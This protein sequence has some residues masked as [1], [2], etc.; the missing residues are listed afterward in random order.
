MAFQLSIHPWVHMAQ[1]DGN[2]WTEKF[3][4]KDHLSPQEESALDENEYAKITARRNNFPE[5]PLIN[6]STQYGLSC[7][8]GLKALPQKDG[9]LKIFRPQ[10]NCARMAQSMKGLR[11]PSID[12][13][14]LLEGIRE[15]IARN[16]ELGFTPSYS[17]SWEEDHWQTAASVYIRP[18]AYSEPGIGIN[19]SRLPWVVTACTTVSAYF[20]PGKNNAVTSPRI[21]ATPGGTGWIK[22]PANYVTS[23]L[24][25]NEAIDAGYMEAIFLDA[26]T[27]KNIEE[28]S[29]CNFFAL[30]PGNVLITPALQDT[31]LPGITRES[32]ITLARDRGMEVV[33][34]A[35]PVEKVLDEAVECF[36][37]GTAAGITPLGSL[38]HNNREKMFSSMENDS[39]SLSL[40]RE[41]KGIQ[42]GAVEDKY[43]WM[44]PV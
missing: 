8:E 11:M 3:I 19:L 28:G 14:L 26:R 43:G 24:A 7:F 1:F 5:L 2:R 12:E 23:I 41:L 39:L 38:C 30:F 29:S 25:K 31:I 27:G 9:S 35:L 16:A 18:F 44:Y 37:T 36:I 10:R 32:V 17:D 20:T 33:E 34:T 40:L 42:Y 4:E 6:Y 15:M 21:R 22:T 13:K